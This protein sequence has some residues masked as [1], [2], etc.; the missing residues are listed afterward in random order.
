M[1]RVDFEKW[2]LRSARI[3]R[4]TQLMKVLSLTFV[5]IPLLVIHA[6][7]DQFVCPNKMTLRAGD[8][9]FCIL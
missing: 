3:S 8:W 4:Y 7:A 1:I 5:A 6:K 9:S 2:R